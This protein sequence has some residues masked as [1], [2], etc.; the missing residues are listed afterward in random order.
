MLFLK[1]IVNK[2]QLKITTFIYNLLDKI[3]CKTRFAN[4]LI[5]AS[6]EINK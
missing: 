2:L 5:V 6:N 4:Y 3:D 1:N